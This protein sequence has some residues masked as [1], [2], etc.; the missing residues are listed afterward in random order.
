VAARETASTATTSSL[1][2]I[3]EPHLS[4]SSGSSNN[5][6]SAAFVY[7]GSAQTLINDANTTGE[8]NW[9]QQIK[10]LADSGSNVTIT[11]AASSVMFHNI[12]SG[13][14]IVGAGFPA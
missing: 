8:S 1:A 7:C 5:S 4:V 13:A 6:F 9:F 2:Q 12:K 3:P 11:K 14:G 10:L